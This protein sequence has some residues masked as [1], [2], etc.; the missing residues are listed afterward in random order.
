MIPQAEKGPRTWQREKSIPE[1]ERCVCSIKEVLRAYS[2]FETGEKLC[3]R[4]LV[5]TEQGGWEEA[6]G[7]R[8]GCREMD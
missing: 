1:R 5:C 3:D 4:N 8:R 2:L 7:R 6:T